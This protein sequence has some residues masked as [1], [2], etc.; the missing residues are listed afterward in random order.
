MAKRTTPNFND[1]TLSGRTQR[2]ARIA[3]GLAI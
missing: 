1:S 3:Q 2:Q